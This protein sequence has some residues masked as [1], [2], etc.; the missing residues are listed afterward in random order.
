L[1]LIPG[2]R[3]GTLILFQEA[4][5]PASMI[6]SEIPIQ[7]MDSASFQAYRHSGKFGFHGPLLALAASVVLGFPL[8]YAYAYF[9]KWVPFIY[10]NVFATFG[11]AAIFGL[12]TGALMKFGRVRNNGVA[13]VTSMLAGFIA[14]YFAWNGHIHSVFRDAPLFV[15]PDEMFFAMKQ[16]Y[17]EGT[18]GF[19]SGSPLTGVLLAIVWVVEAA[20]ILGTA[21]LVA[22]HKVG[23]IPYCETSQCWLDKTKQIDRLAPFTDPAQRAA[24][25]SGDLGPLTQAQPRAEAAVKWTRITLKH[26]PSCQVFHTVRLQEVTRNYDRKGNPKLAVKNLTRDL[27]LPS[28]MFGLITKFEHF[29]E[30]AASSVESENQTPS[31]PV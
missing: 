23:E 16:L 19:A 10:L 17:Q 4:D 2:R 5:I 15:F 11:Y 8:G 3:S 31:A 12:V 29:G 1:T 7:S 14:L 26:S 18:W 21:M 24:F 13:N 30:P 6:N 27:I 25:K 28:E 9:I 22:Y 20:I